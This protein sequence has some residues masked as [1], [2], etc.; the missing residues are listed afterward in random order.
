VS[1]A[2]DYG[3][4]ISGWRVWL[5]VDAEGRSRLASVLYHALWPVRQE[6]VGECLAR[7]SRLWLPSRR[8]RGKDHPV[9]GERCACGIY[10]AGGLSSALAFFGSVGLR[11]LREVEGRPVLHR[12]LGR[13]ALW[14]RL[15]ECEAGW[16]GQLAYPEH[17]F[18]SARTRSGKPVGAL[19]EVAWS[20]A[21]Y[22]VPI[23]I[24]DRVGRENELAA[25]LR[26]HTAV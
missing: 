5:V 9:P 15:V 24:L 21:D 10:A 7:R 20:L 8:S 25:A 11:E 16:R 4:A 3:R 13:V 14:G 1:A 17:L 18:L 2:P 12:V 6:L 23:E 22:R 19:E 26:T